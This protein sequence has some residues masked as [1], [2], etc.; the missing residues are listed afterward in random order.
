MDDF[1]PSSVLNRFNIN[2][3][4][5]HAKWPFSCFSF[6]RVKRAQE[7]VLK[8]PCVLRVQMEIDKIQEKAKKKKRP[9]A[10]ANNGTN[11]TSHVR[12]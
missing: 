1:R 2:V 7:K 9:R 4:H 5:Y 10:Y 8:K 11:V 12:R 6:E 3:P